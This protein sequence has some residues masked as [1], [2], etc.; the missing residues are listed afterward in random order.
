M[1]LVNVNIKEVAK[2]AKV[3]TATVSR[4][5]NKS[6]YV[7]DH[8]RE[9]VLRTVKSLNYIP[10]CNA[11]GLRQSKTF[12]VGMVLP[13]ICN[14]HFSLIFRGAQ[15]ELEK[16]NIGLLVANSDENSE[17]ET[18]AV[19]M[20]F[21]KKVDGL[22][23]TGAGYNEKLEKAIFKSN[24]PTVFLGRKGKGN[25]PSVSINN[26]E[27]MKVMIKNLYN[28]GHRKFYYLG[29]PCNIS[30]SIK[31][32]NAV[33]DFAKE[34]KNV[35]LF[36]TNGDFTY[37]SGFNRTKNFLEEKGVSFDAIVCANDLIAFGAID[38]CRSMNINVPEDVS[39][40]GFDD[41]F[42]AS[43]FVPSLTTI[44]Q[45]TYEIGRRGAE[46]LVEYIDG[47]RKRKVHII[48]PSELVIRD[49]SK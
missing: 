1:I 5:I 14:S 19:N 11:R 42:L 32:L 2:K 45:P 28:I 43:H 20:L 27:S 37:D 18:K 13:D 10:D 3:S 17:K 22:L 6:A 46:L 4:V 21:S 36:T 41:C 26:Y 40:T 44:K 15:F 34:H 33:K 23:F 25:F 29:G 39:I 31:R 35:S 38:A 30:S 47:K 7:S 8:L 24:I 9:R 48:L 49:S 12:T 16:H